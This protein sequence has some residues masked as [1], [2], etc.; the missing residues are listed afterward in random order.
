MAPGDAAEQ[1]D[2]AFAWLVAEARRFATTHPERVL[3]AT[4]AGRRHSDSRSGRQTLGM[5]QRSM[6]SIV[7]RMVRSRRARSSR[8]VSVSA[9]VTKAS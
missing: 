5:G 6:A 8:S 1:P 2:P 4:R 9:W 7:R 3:R